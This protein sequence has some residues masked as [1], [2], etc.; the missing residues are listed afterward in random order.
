MSDFQQ[1]S[2]RRDINRTDP[3][4][5]QWPPLYTSQQN[6]KVRQLC[7]SNPDIRLAQNNFPRLATRNLASFSFDLDAVTAP[8]KRPRY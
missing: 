4:S 1:R 7:R 8:R 2:P 3:A 6:P 5:R